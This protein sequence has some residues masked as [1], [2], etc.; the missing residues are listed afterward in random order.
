MPSSG[1]PSPA[2][3]T[4]WAHAVPPPAR[5][6]APSS[7]RPPSAKATGTLPA[8]APATTPPP[9]A[10]TPASTARLGPDPCATFH[11]FRRDPCYRFLDQLTR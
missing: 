7:T 2:A 4:G 5:T 9:P 8:P 1:A 11:D 10:P 3:T 6:R